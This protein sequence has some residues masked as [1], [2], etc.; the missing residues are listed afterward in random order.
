HPIT[1]KPCPPP[2]RG[3]I[4]RQKRNGEAKGTSFEE[5]ADN[6]EIHF[7][8]DENKVPQ[9]KRFLDKVSS[10][11]SKSVMSDFTDGEKELTNIVGSR[12][13]FPNP[14]PTSIVRDLLALS[15]KNSGYV[16]DF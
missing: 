12:G 5:L 3:W 9:T 4:W 7:G 16:L 1:K 10:D 8:S 15:S 6:H 13:T 11:V 2:K 14:K